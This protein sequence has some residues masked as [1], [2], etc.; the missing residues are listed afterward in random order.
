MKAKLDMILPPANPDFCH[1]K[2]HYLMDSWFIYS[3]RQ[4]LTPKRTHNLSCLKLQIVHIKQLLKL[5]GQ[6]ALRSDGNLIKQ[7]GTWVLWSKSLYCKIY[8]I[9]SYWT[10][11]SKPHWNYLLILICRVGD[12]FNMSCFALPHRSQPTDNECFRFLFPEN[13]FIFFS[14]TSSTLNHVRWCLV[15]GSQNLVN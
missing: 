6:H 11:G 15:Y 7:A 5:W 2:T 12:E 4:C 10:I 1:R 8:P 14:W 13:N 3:F 9:V